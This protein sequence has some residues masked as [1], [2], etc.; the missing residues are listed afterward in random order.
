VDV[1]DDPQAGDMIERLRLTATC[2]ALLVAM[3][4]CGGAPTVPATASPDASATT[5]PTAAPGSQ[6]AGVPVL[7]QPWA[8]IELTDVSTGEVFTLADH[9]GKVVIIETM[10]IWCPTCL[11]QQRSV[12]EALAQLDSSRVEYVV[13]D[14]DLNE[15]AAALASYRAETGFVGSYVI[16]GIPV[17]RALADEFGA[18]ILNPPLTPIV[19][20]GTD[21]TATLTD[22]GRKSAEQLVALAEAA[23]A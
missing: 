17:A 19:I 3:A 8:T 4:A 14:V 9:A 10:A 13:L 5:T 1:I 6:D 16:A 23:G 11:L 12:D 7:D 20:V 22:Y 21:G 18:N 15:D 2:L